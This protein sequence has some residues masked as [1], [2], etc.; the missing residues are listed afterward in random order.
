MQQEVVQLQSQIKDFGYETDDLQEKLNLMIAEKNNSDMETHAVKDM[1][2]SKKSELEREVRNRERLEQALTLQHDSFSK[3]DN[4]IQTKTYENQILK[5]KIVKSELHLKE[6]SLKVEKMAQ[7]IDGL[8]S[9]CTRAQQ[10]YEE[11]VLTVSRLMS[12]NQKQHVEVKGLVEESQRMHEEIRAL[13]RTKDN[14]T[15]KVIIIHF[16]S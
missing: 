2:A 7:E 8:L 5:E 16:I 12:E 10:D 6:E 11:Q 14:L 3:K 4:E 13:Q 15:R 9:K 1:L